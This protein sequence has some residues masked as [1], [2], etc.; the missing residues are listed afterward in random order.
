MLSAS[1]C[2]ALVDKTLVDNK[3]TVNP[4]TDD[5]PIENPSIDYNP[6][7]ES[8]ITEETTT[9]ENPEDNIDYDF[10]GSANN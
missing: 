10:L 1:D 3:P 2:S 8:N 9:E 7:L 4:A 6:L 5:K